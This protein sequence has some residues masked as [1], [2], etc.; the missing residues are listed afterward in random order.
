VSQYIIKVLV[1]AVVIVAATELA[2]RST[3]A[4]AALVALPLTTLLAM[5]WLYHDTGD[6]RQVA[7]LARGVFW[8][9]LPSLALFLAFPWAIERGWG[10]WRAMA[11]GAAA[12]VAGYGALVLGLRAFGIRL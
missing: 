8:L 9:V 12:T 2:K 1:S 11:L 3:W 4:G 6:V 7:T 5:Y 10:F